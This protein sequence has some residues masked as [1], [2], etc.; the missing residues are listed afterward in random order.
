MRLKGFI[1]SGLLIATGIV[2]AQTDFRPGYI[3]KSSGDTVLGQID[4]RGDLLMCSLCKFKATDNTITDYS[5]NE[6]EAFRFFESKYFVTKEINDKK[7]FMEYL[8]NGKV[9]IYY[10]RDK[11]G[12]HY[13]IDKENERLSEIPY[14]EGIKYVGNDRLLYESTKHIGFLKYYMKDAP[15]LQSRIQSLKKPDHL[16]LIKL[17]EDYHNTVCEGEKCIIYEKKQPFFKVGLEGLIGVAN[18]VNDKDII[19]KSYF[20]KGAFVHIGIPTINEKIYFKIGLLHSRVE[21]ND[22]KKEK[23]DDPEEYLK[24]PVHIA[25]LA[26]K[27]Y[28]IRPSFSIGLLSASYSAGVAVRIDKYVNLGI[29]SWLNFGDKGIPWIPTRFSNYAILGSLYIGL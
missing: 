18:F 20:Q 12:D 27:T 7:V 29:Q 28:R 13:Y 21:F 14:E 23:K 17:A 6:I 9:N 11:S 24:A 8:I 3:I 4:Y 15:G 25:Y 26:P 19:A 2:H 16:S 22:E 5:P 10:M 1:L